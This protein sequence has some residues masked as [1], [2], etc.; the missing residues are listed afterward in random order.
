MAEGE[1]LNQICR[2][3]HMPA[4][5]TVAAWVVDDIQG[6]AKQYRQARDRLLE[7]WA[8]ELIEISDDSRNDWIKR[9]HESGR[10]EVLC[11]HEHINRARLRADNRK[12]LLSK[13]KPGEYG[14]T[15]TLNVNNNAA[16]DAEPVS[17]TAAWLDGVLGEPADDEAP[18]PLPH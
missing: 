9:E 11:D 8:D 18:P 1:N 5:T 2:D 14:E 10:T 17:A 6:F 7:Y 13:L 16:P 4:R 3:E 12:W 15:R